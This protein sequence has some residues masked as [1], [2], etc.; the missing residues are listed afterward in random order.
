MVKIGIKEL[1]KIVQEE[2]RRKTLS[3]SGDNTSDAVATFLADGIKKQLDTNL[4]TKAVSD[5]FA[6][7]KGGM[8]FPAKAEDAESL[9]SEIAQKVMTRLGK[10][11]QTFVESVVTQAVGK[12]L[13]GATGEK[14]HVT[15][16]AFGSANRKSSDEKPDCGDCE[17]VAILVAKDDADLPG[18]YSACASCGYDHEYEYAEAQA[19]HSDNPDTED[20]P[21]GDCDIC[22]REVY[23]IHA[24]CPHCGAGAEPDFDLEK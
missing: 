21:A 18:D 14:G 15:T 23:D 6:N 13:A 22:G 17:S 3:E 12:Q 16:E 11:L 5:F 24:V 4:A 7:Q 1:R 8:L 20:Q 2:M 9:K 10:E 19:W